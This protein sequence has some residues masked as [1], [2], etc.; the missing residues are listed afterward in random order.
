MFSIVVY[1]TTMQWYLCMC[2]YVY[3]ATHAVATGVHGI[4]VNPTMVEEDIAG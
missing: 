4:T 2:N 3:T 1:F